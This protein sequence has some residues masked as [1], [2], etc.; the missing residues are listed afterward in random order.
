MK[1]EKQIRKEERMRVGYALL[2]LINEYGNELLF[3]SALKLIAE[4]LLKRGIG[5]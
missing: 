3:V 5:K 2:G 1:S 4:S